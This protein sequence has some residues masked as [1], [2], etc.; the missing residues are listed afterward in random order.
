MTPPSFRVPMNVI[1][2][3]QAH[4]RE[5]GARHEE[6]V[7]LWRGTLDPPQATAAL[8]PLQESSYGRFRVPLTE[9]QRIARELAGTGETI[10][11]QVHSH[12]GHAFHSAIDDAEAIPRRVGALSLVVPDFGVRPELLDDAELFQLQQDGRWTPAPLAVLDIEVTESPATR[13][14]RGRWWIA[15]LIARLSR[16]A[17]SL[18]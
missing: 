1:A 7:V 17:R 4:L 9:R 18:T 10:L 14:Q 15:W 11:V 3:T 16:H 6:G 8:V 5:C 12:P 2:T 13:R